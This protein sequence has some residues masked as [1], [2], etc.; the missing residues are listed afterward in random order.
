MD[1]VE[2]IARLLCRNAGGDPDCPVLPYFTPHLM[3]TPL[4]KV[5][6]IQLP[7]DEASPLWER[8]R[9]V[10]Q[11]VLVDLRNSERQ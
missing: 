9:G 6:S 10:A 2:R 1:D 11:S 7:R 5:Q 8:W 4:G 3:D